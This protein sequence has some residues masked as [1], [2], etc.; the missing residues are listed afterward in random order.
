MAVEIERI[1]NS[2]STT[3]MLHDVPHL[4]FILAKWPEFGPNF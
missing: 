3:T 2:D 4:Y 1:I